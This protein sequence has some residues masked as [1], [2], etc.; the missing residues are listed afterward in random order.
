[1]NTLGRDIRVK[2]IPE[3][4]AKCVVCNHIETCCAVDHDLRGHICRADYEH[5]LLAE[6]Q[7]NLI[8]LQIP[9]ES[10]FDL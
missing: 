10:L 2:L 3:R 9:T 5:V 1:M 8:G 6:R 4:L 7:L